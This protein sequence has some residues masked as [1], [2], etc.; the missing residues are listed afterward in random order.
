MNF[1]LHRLLKII[2]VEIDIKYITHVR[3]DVDDVPIATF[4][5]YLWMIYRCQ[6]HDVELRS[7]DAYLCPE[8]LWVGRHWL[9]RP[10]TQVPPQFLMDDDD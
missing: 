6:K 3:Y 9:R 5:R 8:L 4:S 2:L 7:Y 10:V 1:S